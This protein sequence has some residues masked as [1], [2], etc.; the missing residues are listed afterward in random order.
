MNFAKL[1]VSWGCGPDRLRLLRPGAALAAAAVEALQA[2]HFQ[3]CTPA[4]VRPD[5][6]IAVWQIG[7]SLAEGTGSHPIHD[8]PGVSTTRPDYRTEPQSPRLS[9]VI[10]TQSQILSTTCTPITPRVRGSVPHVGL[11]AKLVDRGGHGKWVA[12]CRP[13]PRSRENT[14]GCTPGR[15]RRTR[16]GSLMRSAQSLAGVGTT[17]ADAWWPQP[18][19][20]QA[21]AK[22]GGAQG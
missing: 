14:P 18:S 20:H 21:S 8:Q 5:F 19:A 9:L 11:P 13:G 1:A 2:V 12:W 6:F 10:S 3:R 17:R 7:H 4:V 15:R 16:D 22:A